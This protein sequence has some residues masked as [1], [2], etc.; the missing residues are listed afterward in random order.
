MPS[1]YED[2]FVDSTTSTASVASKEEETPVKSTSIFYVVHKK[3]KRSLVFYSNK[4]FL[5][6]FTRMKMLAN[7]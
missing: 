1:K 7:W 4:Y 5:Y 2:S 3:S 6:I